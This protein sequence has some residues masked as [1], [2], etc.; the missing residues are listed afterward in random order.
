MGKENAPM[1]TIARKTA[2]RGKTLKIPTLKENAPMVAIAIITSKMEKTLKIPTL[3]ETA[4]MIKYIKDGKDFDK[5]NV[6]GNDLD[7]THAQHPDTDLVA[8]LMEEKTK[9]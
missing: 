7:G 2:K 8:Q 4:S 5:H 6:E 3:K 1:V 9:K